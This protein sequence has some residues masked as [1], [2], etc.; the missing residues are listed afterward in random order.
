MKTLASSTIH[1]LDAT[2]KYRE[3]I[4]KCQQNFQE[5]KFLKYSCVMNKNFYISFNLYF[6]FDQV[7]LP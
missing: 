1:D 3:V 2:I 5:K 6:S 7:D 4:Q